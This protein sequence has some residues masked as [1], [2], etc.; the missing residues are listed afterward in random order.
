MIDIT[1]L[2]ISPETS[3]NAALTCIDNNLRGIA[4]VVDEQHHLLGTVVD[5]DIR[6]AILSGL[7]F[8]LPV[9]ELLSRK[10]PHYIRPVSVR[11][12]TDKEII[13]QLMKERSVRHVPLVNELD[14]VVGLFALDDFVVDAQMP[15]SMQAVVMA[16]GFG[17]RL[18][19]LTENVPKP[20]L[21]VGDRP[22]ME[23]IVDQ[24][25]SAGIRQVNVTTHYR[26]EKIQ[27]HFGDG[28]SF[29]VALN[30]IS[31]GSPLG[32]AGGVGLVQSTSQP[33]LVING[34]ILTNINFNDML[35]YHRE[36]D[37]AL[38]VAVRKYEFTVPYGVVETD[39]GCIKRVVEKPYYEVFVNAGI[40][41]LE[42]RVHSMIH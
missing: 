27:E 21:P 41:L 29:G 16:G 33:L 34:D 15:A 17:K 2:F 42:P 22:L 6:R 28:S 36:C 1:Q 26:A 30:Y 4:L 20:M 7:S 31:E 14:Q 8:D 24:L 18:L 35:A 38:T 11:E 3:I 9:T 32:T 5:G 13:V 40:Y 39:K 19:P 12:A 37:A 25:R 10:P 23:H